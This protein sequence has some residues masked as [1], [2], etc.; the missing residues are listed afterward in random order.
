MYVHCELS[1]KNTFFNFTFSELEKNQPGTVLT[2]LPIVSLMPVPLIPAFSNG[3][4]ERCS[5]SSAKYIIF[6]SFSVLAKAA[7]PILETSSPI[8]MLLILVQFS[9][10]FSPIQIQLIS[11]CSNCLQFLKAPSPIIT[12]FSL[13]VLGI[14]ISESS[15]ERPV[16]I[17]TPEN[18]SKIREG[19]YWS[20]DFPQENKF[21][22]LKHLVLTP[23]QSWEEQE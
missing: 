13:Y 2:F 17:D 20:G 19:V 23:G 6:V 22:K 1:S 4:P 3:P 12:G 8:T 16:T 21:P 11:T 18:S 5:M 10:A 14:I 9:N 7:S 15:E